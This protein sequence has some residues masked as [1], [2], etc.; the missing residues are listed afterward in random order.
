MP[1]SRD[2]LLIFYY[3]LGVRSSLVGLYY[4]EAVLLHAVQL[5][6]DE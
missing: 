4:L 5:S 3:F 2:E 1:H 6:S